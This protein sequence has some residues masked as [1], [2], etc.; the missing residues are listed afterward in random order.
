MAMLHVAPAGS[1][2]LLQLSEVSVNCE[3][4]DP[5]RVAAVVVTAIALWFVTVK[6]SG[7]ELAPSRIV[8]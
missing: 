2:V 5:T 8:P 7:G 6:V 1:V 4:G 3:V